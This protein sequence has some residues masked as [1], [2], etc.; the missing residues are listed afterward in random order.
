MLHLS[1]S[2]HCLYEMCNLDFSGLSTLRVEV[3]QHIGIHFSRHLQGEWGGNLMKSDVSHFAFLFLSRA[4][5][6]NM[7]TRLYLFWIC[8]HG[9]SCGVVWLLQW[10]LS[11]PGTLSGDAW[12][13]RFAVVTR[14]V[15][16][17]V[18]RKYALRA[19]HITLHLGPY[20]LQWKDIKVRKNRP[21]NTA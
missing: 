7:E 14:D 5:G 18:I 21:C 4:Y 12:N 16:D 17:L 10:L 8:L 15:Y 20:A 13:M 2:F 11:W 6:R 9:W 3:F 19:A 1:L